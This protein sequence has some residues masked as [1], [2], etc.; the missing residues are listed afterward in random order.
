MAQKVLHILHLQA[1]EQRPSLL[2][3]LQEKKLEQI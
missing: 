2:Q 3:I 1:K